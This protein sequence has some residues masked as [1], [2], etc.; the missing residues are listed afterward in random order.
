LSIRRAVLLLCLLTAFTVPPTVAQAQEFG[1][2]KSAETINKG[3]FK[4]RV[5]PLLMVG[6]NV[7][8]EPGVAILAGYGV[9]SNV[10][11]EGGVAFYDGVTFWGAA[12]EV[13]LVKERWFDFSVA[14]GL[15]RRT[16]DRTPGLAVADG[17]VGLDLRFLASGHVTRRLELYGGVDLAFEGVGASSSP[18]SPG[19]VLPNPED[20]KTVHLVPGIQFRITHNIDFVAEAGVALNDSGRPYIAGGL[21]LYVR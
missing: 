11:V 4:L 9:T 7:E 16:G 3:N 6:K 8:D 2:L 14:G 21:V 5:S 12:A 19:H 15:H 10:D 18:L 13:R 20:F 1:L 17:V